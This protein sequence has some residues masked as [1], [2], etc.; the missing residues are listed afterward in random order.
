MPTYEFVCRDCGK[1]FEVTRPAS[2][3]EPAKVACPGC[4]SKSVER[5][6]SRVFAITS[7]KS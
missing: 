5:R 1:T 3:Y 4:K 7:K 2:K 6:W